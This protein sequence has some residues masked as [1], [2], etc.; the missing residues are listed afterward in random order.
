MNGS[1]KSPDDSVGIRIAETALAEFIKNGKVTSAKCDVCG[2]LIEMSW[3]GDRQS[4]V[5][6]KCSC[7]KFHGSLRG[8]LN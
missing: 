4:A 8:L 2:S 7:G 1:S 3:L 6:I 5:S